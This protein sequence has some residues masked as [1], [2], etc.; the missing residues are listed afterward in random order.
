MLSV[1]QN[2]LLFVSGV[3]ILQGVLLAFI[4][5]FHPRAEKSTSIFLAL[6]IVCISVPMLLPLVRH[7]LPWQFYIY[8]APVSLL[9]GP[10]LYLYVRSFKEVITFKKAWPHFL[11][12]LIY[13][14]II[15]YVS[16]I[17]G[18]SFPPGKDMPAA[19]LHN[20]YTIIPI[21]LRYVQMV[22]YYFMARKALLSYRRSIQHLFSE[23]SRIDLGWMRLLVNGYIVLVVIA[24]GLYSLAL[25]YSDYYGTL[26]LVNA[27]VSSPYIYMAT[28]KGISQMALWQIQPGMNKEKVEQEM[29]TAEAIELSTVKEEKEAAVKVKSNDGKNDEIAGKIIEVMEKEKLYQE[30]EL[31]LQQLADK[32][33]YPSYQVS[34]ALNEKMKKNFYDLVNGYRV[35]EAKRLLL[36]SKK[37]NYTILSIGFEAGFNSKTTFNTVFKKF[38]GLTPTQY[39]DKQ[40]YPAA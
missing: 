38:T 30:A 39:R 15:S 5:R 31:T 37:S 9:Q 22:I 35:E 40:V 18:K 11:L 14:F 2:I 33:H 34:Q 20:P 27:A 24:I 12:S 16:F 4:I 29:S 23:T 3:G 28:Y 25:Q 36:D 19:I 7:F 10:L 6:Y 1:S 8:L 26:I 17:L 21:S 13:F 32:L